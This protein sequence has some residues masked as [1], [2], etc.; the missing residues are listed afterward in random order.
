VDK[1]QDTGLQSPLSFYSH[2][3]VVSIPNTDDSDPD[4]GDQDDNDPKFGNIDG[5]DQK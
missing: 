3:H 2:S 1:A 5:S 4:G